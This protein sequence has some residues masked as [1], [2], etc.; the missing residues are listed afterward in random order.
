M[1]KKS[2]NNLIKVIGVGVGITIITGVIFVLLKKCGNNTPCGKNN[3]Y[4]INGFEC[5]DNYCVKIR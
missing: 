5:E 2:T 1:L 3:T 4:C